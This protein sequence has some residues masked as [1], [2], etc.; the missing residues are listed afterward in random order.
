M[1]SRS[2][3]SEAAESGSEPVA[4]H[5]LGLGFLRKPAVLGLAIVIALVLCFRWARS[6]QKPPPS[7]EQVSADG[8]LPDLSQTYADDKLGVF[9]ARSKLAS[10]LG[11][12]GD[13]LSTRARVMN[14][15]RM[16]N[17]LVA[18]TDGAVFIHATQPE[19]LPDWISP[20]KSVQIEGRITE[21]KTKT[22]I[23]V[24]ASRISALN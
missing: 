8:S 24:H 14:V 5:G 10:V 19:G 11:K 12:Q 1:K 6:P 16:K 9:G 22:N 13:G 23:Y 2:D 3:R 20:G 15:F 18:V 4:D 21:V 17:A 7:S